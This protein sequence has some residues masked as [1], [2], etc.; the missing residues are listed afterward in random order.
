[1]GVS[2]GGGTE[3]DSP[4]G[5]PRGKENGRDDG[6][7]RD[8]AGEKLAQQGGG[9][10]E[11]G[12]SR[13]A[14]LVEQVMNRP[15]VNQGGGVAEHKQATVGQESDE[16]V[17]PKTPLTGWRLSSTVMQLPLTF[18]IMGGVGLVLLW[19]VARRRRQ[20]R[21]LSL[22]LFWRRADRLRYE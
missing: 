10:K 4:P 2:K 8:I 6:I 1:V 16:V 21:R 13:M 5:M 3:S 11:N 14:E 15:T 18:S 7:L 12:G 22:P 20:G 9:A 19:A 17:K